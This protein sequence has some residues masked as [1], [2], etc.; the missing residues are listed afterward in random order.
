MYTGIRSNDAMLVCVLVRHTHAQFGR[1][2]YWTF[3]VNS[4]GLVF[5]S[6]RIMS[7]IL[8]LLLLH[9][10][11]NILKTSQHPTRAHE[12]THCDERRNCVVCRATITMHSASGGQF[13]IDKQIQFLCSEVVVVFIA[14]LLLW[15]FLATPFLWVIRCSLLWLERCCALNN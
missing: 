4:Q 9:A 13:V 6:Q 3:S 7:L 5:A 10:K 1:H 12:L 15:L 8:K 2:S 14:F 11:S